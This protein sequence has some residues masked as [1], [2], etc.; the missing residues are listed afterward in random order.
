MQN[1]QKTIL[2]EKDWS[3]VDNIAQFRFFQT[4]IRLT[5]KQNVQNLHKSL[6]LPQPSEVRWTDEILAT[7]HLIKIL[8][9]VEIAKFLDFVAV[10]EES[11]GSTRNCSFGQFITCSKFWKYRLGSHWLIRPKLLP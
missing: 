4:S 11:L 7:G 2:P 9:E 3:I 1:K 6:S 10:R 8:E 5:L